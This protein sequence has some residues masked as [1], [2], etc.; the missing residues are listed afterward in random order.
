MSDRVL[1]IAFDH[2]NRGSYDLA[3]REARLVLRGDPDDLTAQALLAMALS[4]QKRGRESAEALAS[5][6]Q[7]G[8]DEPFVHFARA[9]LAS[10]R[11]DHAGA[12]EAVLEAIRLD[13][14]R[15]DFHGF[16]ARQQMLQGRIEEGLATA[17][18][19][20]KLD[21]ECG[22]CLGARARALAALE[23][24]DEA[25]DAVQRALVLEPEDPLLQAL[26]GRLLYQRGDA[27]GALDAFTESLK[28][29]P[30][31][32]WARDG[33]LKALKQRY[34]VYGGFLRFLS[35]WSKVPVP[36][37]TIL[38]LALFAAP[39]AW[40]RHYRNSP[41][42]G[43]AGLLLLIPI[44]G[45]AVVLVSNALTS[46]LL[47]L[48]RFGRRLLTPNDLFASNFALGCLAAVVPPL[49]IGRMPQALAIPMAA[50]YLMIFVPH[51]ADV[52]RRFACLYAA[53]LAALA[54][55]SYATGPGWNPVLML[56]IVGA[57][58]YPLIAILLSFKLE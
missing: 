32:A 53:L 15:A 12:E 56:A 3:E 10:D 2:F 39:I 41:S 48:N 6:L 40:F 22:R 44:I 47:R 54:G 23:R 27:A 26:R 5:A 45:A 13:P 9:I 1:Q 18:A 38:L 49:A 29:D 35:L 30:T 11:D 25:Y 8:P 55:A 16:R 24:R 46:T 37:R 57:V 42:M 20:L 4:R 58:F 34:L 31:E 36:V 17:E 19:G 7:R 21:P 52:P 50:L 51:V 33:L 14:G 28:I 43:T